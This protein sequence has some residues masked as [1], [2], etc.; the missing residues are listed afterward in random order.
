MLLEVKDLVMHYGGV[1]AVG[2]VLFQVPE[3]AVVSLIGT[4]GAGKSTLL[5]IISGLKAPTDGELR[6]QGQHIAGSLPHVIIRLGIAHV[7]RGVDCS[8]K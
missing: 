8:R 2:G 7:L 3:G 1:I 5:R 4:N 6:F